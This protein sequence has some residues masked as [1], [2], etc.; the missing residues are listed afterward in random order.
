[1]KVTSTMKSVLTSMALATRCMNM[2]SLATTMDR[3]ERITEHLNVRQAHT[4]DVLNDSGRRVVVS[5]DQVDSLMVEVIDRVGMDVRNEMPSV[6][7]VSQSNTTAVCLSLPSSSDP[8]ACR[9]RLDEKLAKLRND[10]NN[11]EVL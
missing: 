4:N 2:L 5:S 1:M 6:A 3:F 11:Y 7:G 9:S 10:F 8:I